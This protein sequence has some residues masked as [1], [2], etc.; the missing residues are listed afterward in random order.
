MNEY[1]RI[2]VVGSSGCGKS[3]LSKKLSNILS[4]EYVELDQLFWGKNWSSPRDEEFLTRVETALVGDRWILDG[5][6]TRTIPIKWKRCELVIWID[7]PFFKV[8]FQALRRAI[9]RIISKKEIWPET[10]NRESFVR[11]FMTRDSI[12]LW[13]ITNFKRVRK[14]Y[15]TLQ[16][17]ENYKHI[18]FV[19]LRSTKEINNFLSNLGEGD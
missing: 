8:F 13:T 12:L 2:N 14:K 4:I 17:D 19:R 11:T 1:K 6:F 10:G 15:E 7:L 9:Q 16:R 3:T 5:N 18:H